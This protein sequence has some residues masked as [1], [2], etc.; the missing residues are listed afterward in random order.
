MTKPIIFY[1]S[2]EESLSLKIIKK[3][4]YKQG[5]VTVRHFPD[6]ESFVQIHNNVKN[7][8]TVIVCSL[9]E[10]D[11][12]IIALLFLM[13]LVRELGAKSVGLV[14]P[15]L[16]YLRQDKRFNKGE[17]I[18]SKT[19]AKIISAYSDWIITIDPHLHRY[20]TLDEIYSIPFTV[21][22]TADL[23]C[24]WIYKHIQKPV[25]IV[26]PDLGSKQMVSD[27]A[28]KMKVPYIV[29][30][31][32]RMGDKDVE[33]FGTDIDKYK[34]YKPVIVDDMI[35][36]ANTMTATIKHLSA[37]GIEQI[38]CIGIHG[39]FTIDGYEIL[40][41]S[42]VKKIATTNT[43]SHSTN[44]IDVSDLISYELIKRFS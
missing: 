22:Y 29:L 20:K 3:T 14:A 7:H 33:I 28:K 6:E 2:Q 35:S 18:T 21:L 31:K 16:G 42:G 34:D 15:Y 30:R 19:F 10:P 23:V 13:D 32:K 26:G 39:V 8:D 36:T 4:G 43:I 11:T 24:E 12:K 9:N 41:N 37:K 25:L 40:K 5:K 17:S 38:A 1:F 27:L 44:Q